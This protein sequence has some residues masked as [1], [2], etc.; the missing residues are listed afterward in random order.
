MWASFL[1]PVGG[2]FKPNKFG[3]YDMIGNAWEWCSDYYGDY[4]DGDAVDPIG[5]LVG[6]ERGSR[7]LRGGSWNF[8]PRA[9]VRTAMHFRRTT[10]ATSLG[11]PHLPRR[12]RA[13]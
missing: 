3:L 11:F 6:D 5:P 7:V 9:V 10:V 13:S 8:F 1:Y 12:V 4:P 2:L